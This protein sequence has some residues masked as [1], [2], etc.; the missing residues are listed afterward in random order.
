[1]HSTKKIVISER[2]NLEEKSGILAERAKILATVSQKAQDQTLTLQETNDLFE[3]FNNTYDAKY[4][5]CIANDGVDESWAVRLIRESEQDGSV[6]AKKRSK[7]FRRV[8]IE[9]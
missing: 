6:N 7:H 1:M 9:A 2:T 3:Q 8:P 5:S 4:I